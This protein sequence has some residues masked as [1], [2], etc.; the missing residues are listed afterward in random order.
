MTGDLKMVNRGKVQPLLVNLS[1]STGPV[2]HGACGFLYGLGKADVPSFNVLAPLKPQVAAQKPENGLQHPNGDALDVSDTY[3]AAGGREIEIYI[4]DLYANWPYETLGLEDYL[5]KIEAAMQVVLQ[6]PNRDLFSWVPLNE[7]DQIWYNKTDRKQALF[8]D[9]LVI[10][11][12]IKSIDPAA[13]IVGPNFANY[14]SEVYREFFTFA[15]DHRCLPEVTSWHELNDD[16]FAGWDQRYADYRRIETDL[17][18]SPREICINEYCRINGDLSVPG[19]QVQW[20]A[21]FENSKVDACLAY[22]TDAGSLNNLVTRDNAYK[23][24][25]AWWLYRWYASLT[26]NTVAV[27]PP[28]ALAEG[29]QGLAAVDSAKKQVRVLLG[30]SDGPVQVTVSGLAEAGITGN[31]VHVLVWAA[32]STGFHPSLGPALVLEKN[33]NVVDDQVVVMLENTMETTAYQVVIFPAQEAPFGGWPYTYPAVFAELDGGAQA[34]YSPE[35]ACVALEASSAMTFVIAVEKNG[36]YR[37]RLNGIKSPASEATLQLKVNGQPLQ[38]LAV[39]A[40]EAE[41]CVFLPAGVNSLIY[42]LVSGA[43]PLRVASL[44]LVPGK[45]FSK[46]YEAEAPENGLSGTAKVLEDPAASGKKLV[47]EIGSGPENALEFCQV[48]VLESGEYR[49]VVTFAN[50][51][52]RGGHSYN[53]QVVDRSA[54][55]SVNGADAQMVYF[56]NTFAWNNY[57]TRIM[58]VTLQAGANTIRFANSA[59]N[60]FAPQIDKIEIAA[61]LG[62]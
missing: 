32:E 49:L 9:W 15:R 17:G 21:R 8:E 36:F 7:P 45:G 34:E 61:R 55:V 10:Y 14:D 53:S 52:F 18:I 43:A 20:L 39:S 19:K 13:R 23:A 29:L 47:G 12:K 48:E 27:V 28:D 33:E 6:S 1:E 50:A 37:L 2:R 31:S 62:D 51:E 58:N 3:R 30:G 25:G 60:S 42:T 4:Q 56:R 59:R 16:F 40:A 24:T 41:T 11:Q 22:W 5:T 44:A 57:Q 46:V 38:S 35:G 26:G 54:E